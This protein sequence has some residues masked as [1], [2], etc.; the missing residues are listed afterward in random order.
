MLVDDQRVR[1]LLL[2][3]VAVRHPP[4]EGPQLQPRA[5]RDPDR[6]RQLP[7]I[8]RQWILGMDGRPHWSPLVDDHP[9]DHHRVRGAPLSAHQRYQPH[10]RRLHPPGAVRGRPLWPEPELS[11]RAFPDRGA[12][13]GQRLLLPPGSNLRWA[14]GAR[15]DLLRHQLQPRLWHPDAGGYRGRR[16]QF[17]DRIAP[18]PR[19]QGK[20]LVS[21]LVVA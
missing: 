11:L 13:G 18:R 7:G 3:L 17:R 10:H 9:G 1:D 20:E 21:D 16:D 5:G 19:D 4:A 15:P 2:D 8:R 14:G 6:H 12:G